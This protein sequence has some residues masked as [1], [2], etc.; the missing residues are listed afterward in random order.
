MQLNRHRL[1][2]TENISAPGTS[3]S[4]KH[5]KDQIIALAQALIGSISSGIGL[6]GSNACYAASIFF[7]NY[8]A[9]GLPV[10]GFSF[11]ADEVNTYR[12]LSDTFRLLFDTSLEEFYNRSAAK[13]F[14][15][16]KQTEKKLRSNKLKNKNNP[17]KLIV[18]DP[19][20]AFNW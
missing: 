10:S 3:I 11:N 20:G 15:G 9:S 1:P 18:E 12:S 19:E 14:V 4:A 8:G 13:E 2:Q 17:E 16:K 6:S 7:S 5:T